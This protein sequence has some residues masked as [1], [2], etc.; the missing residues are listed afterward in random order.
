MDCFIPENFG[1]IAEAAIWIMLERE[2]YAPTIA[3]ES[4]SLH[5]L[6]RW[7]SGRLEETVQQRV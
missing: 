7:S 6:C 4:K 3:E 2:A 1:C 5:F